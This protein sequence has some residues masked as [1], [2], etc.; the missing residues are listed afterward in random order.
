MPTRKHKTLIPKHENH[1][2]AHP[3]QRIYNLEYCT[4]KG[5]DQ[6][7]LY[8]YLASYCKM[9]KILLGRRFTWT[10]YT[11]NINHF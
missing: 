3:P 2:I 11:I 10:Q 6:E 7:L 5:Y 8:L 4:S 9:S 1:L